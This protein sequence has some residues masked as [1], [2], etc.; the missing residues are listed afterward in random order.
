M[1]T[2]PTSIELNMT[3]DYTI[4]SASFGGLPKEI[5]NNIFKDGRA[6]AHFIEPWLAT[7]YPLEHVSGC[8]KYDF[9][10]RNYPETKY[11]EKTFT[12]R[13]CKFPPSNM[14]GQ[15]RS[16][17][18][19]VFEEKTKKLIFCIVSNVNFPDIKVRFVKGEDLLTKYPSGTIPF[20]DH[21]K[22]F[23]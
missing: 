17:N 2:L 1:S 19:D 22:F 12:R 21:I 8:K 3:Y 15:G 16:I 13:G 14:I 23:N 18:R 10:D 6:F 5:V 7:K 20:R 9:T 4:T 11:D